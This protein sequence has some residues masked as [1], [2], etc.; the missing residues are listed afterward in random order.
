MKHMVLY[1]DFFADYQVKNI[2]VYQGDND[3][4]G[5]KHDDKAVSR[6]L[7]NCKKFSEI[8]KESRPDVT[9]YFMSP[10]PS[11]ARWKLWPYYQEAF[12]LLKDYA[13]ETENIKIID[14]TSTMLDEKGV[15]REDIFKP[16]RLH[17]NAKGYE[18]WTREVRKALGL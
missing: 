2:L 12:R 9:I 17:M 10:K 5:A 3:L 13:R 7:D 8:M 11:P 1:A 16:D 18:I 14:I 6:F 15:V 4:V